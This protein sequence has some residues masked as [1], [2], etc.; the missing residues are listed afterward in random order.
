MTRTSHSPLQAP[1]ALRSAGS[2][3]YAPWSV[4]PK[5]QGMVPV[6]VA[7]PQ[8]PCPH[9]VVPG[10]L[11]N[12][13]CP[14]TP[15]SPSLAGPSKL[16]GLRRLSPAP[17]APTSTPTHV[18]PTTPSGP[19]QSP[20]EDF[21]ALLPEDTV[22]PGSAVV[23]PGRTGRGKAGVRNPSPVGLGM[24]PSFTALGFEQNLS[25][26]LAVAGE[27]GG[28]KGQS[29][30]HWGRGRGGEQGRQTAGSRQACAYRGPH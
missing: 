23:T 11:Q 20:W 24:N 16:S 7:S 29:V 22:S 17:K 18:P 6:L 5:G 12:I 25:V 13:P 15:S 19:P 30:G 26:H 21:P 1:P 27:A 10:R 8:P 28:P 3:G 14:A 9:P 2:S 4:S